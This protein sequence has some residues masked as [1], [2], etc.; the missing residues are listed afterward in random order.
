[1]I[2]I[3]NVNVV[4]GKQPKRA[5][6]LIEQGLERADIRDQTGLIVGVQ[7]AN[8][9]VKKGEICVLMGLSGSGKSSLLRCLNGLNEVTAGAFG[10]HT[11]MEWRTSTKDRKSTR[12]NPS[13]LRNPYARLCLK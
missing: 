1:M 2:E 13:H 3:E 11:A 5:L 10:Y 6:P 4:F 7:N 9:S 8:L 12:P